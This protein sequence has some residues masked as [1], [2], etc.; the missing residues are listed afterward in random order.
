MTWN[1]QGLPKKLSDSDF[2]EIINEFDILIFTET[3][4]AKTS[5]YDIENFDSFSCPRPKCNKKAKRESG[6]VIVYFK[7]SISKGLKLLN[8]N[9]KGIIWFKMDSCGI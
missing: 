7:K 9:E 4:H 1:V 6:G 5:K 8:I 2:L 3:W